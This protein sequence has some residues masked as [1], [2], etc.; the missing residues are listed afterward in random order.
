MAVVFHHMGTPT[1]TT[2]AQNDAMTA[3][4]SQALCVVSAGGCLGASFAL[5]PMVDVSSGR[6]GC[7]MLS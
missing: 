5:L 2:T 6:A 4:R 7:A 3:R 1:R